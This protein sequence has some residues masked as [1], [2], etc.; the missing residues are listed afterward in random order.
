MGSWENVL[1]LD[2]HRNRVCGSTAGLCAALERGAD[3]RIGTAFRHNEHID[4]ASDCAELIRERM[5]FRVTYV[6]ERRWAAGIE[7][8]RMPVEL[9]DGFG[10]R[11]SLSFFLYNQD[12]AQ[13]IGRPSLSDGPPPPGVSPTT[14]GR[15]PQMHRMTLVQANDE[16]TNAPSHHFF[17]AFDYF[18]FFVRDGWREVLAHTEQGEVVS[19]SLAALTE[20]VDAGCEV[21]VGIRD[22]C[23]D[24]GE[25]PSHEVFVHLG[26]CYHYTER[27]VLIGA[28]HPLVRVR[29]TIPLVYQSRGWDFGWLLMRTDGQVA[30]WLCNPYTLRFEKS[31][32]RHAVRWFVDTAA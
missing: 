9:P 22:L 32:A 24:L 6:L 28:A 12:G 5:D 7:T 8:L 31:A 17:Y 21:K 23:A 1:Q 10:A 2:E 16:G 14:P 11:P 29:P 13:A 30:R 3:L 4:T 15:D 27:G 26:P 25:G 20:A 18:R 19:G